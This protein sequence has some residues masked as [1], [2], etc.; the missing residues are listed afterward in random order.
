MESIKNRNQSFQQLEKDFTRKKRQLQILKAVFRH[1][2]GITNRELSEYLHLPIN[3][4]TGR[5]NELVSGKFVKELGSK[6]D[7]LTNRN[8]TVWG[9]NE[10]Y[11]F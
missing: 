4:I 2:K 11:K 8:V 5:V 10:N 1:E 9:F 7:T 6:L 3:C